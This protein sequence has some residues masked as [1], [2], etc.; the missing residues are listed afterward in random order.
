MAIRLRQDAAR[1]LALSQA[2]GVDL[3]LH[4]R[5]VDSS[6]PSGRALLQMS[7]V[8]AEF[9]RAMLLERIGAGLARAKGQGK[10]LGRPRAKRCRHPQAPG[11]GL[12]MDTI[13]KQLGCRIGRIQQVLKAAG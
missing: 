1:N 4:Q 2:L 11:N 6:T 12:G 5:H 3:Y 8:F 13:R 7:G 10:Q 9:E